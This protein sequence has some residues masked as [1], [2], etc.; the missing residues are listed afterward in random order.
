[1]EKPNVA[2]IFDNINNIVKFDIDLNDVSSPSRTF[3]TK[4]GSLDSINLHFSNKVIDFKKSLYKQLLIKVDINL[5][6]LLIEESKLRHQKSQQIL[7]K[8]KDVSTTLLDEKLNNDDQEEEYKFALR[9]L[10]SQNKAIGEVKLILLDT[11]KF[12]EYTNEEDY[13]RMLSELENEN[14]IETNKRNVNKA[15]FNLSKTDSILFLYMLEKF[16]ILK[17]ESSSQRKSFIEQNFNY[18]EYRN[19]EMASDENENIVKKLTGINV[20]YS[21]IKSIDKSNVKRYNKRLDLLK[22]KIQFIMEYEFKS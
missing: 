3:S 13:K 7:S 17:F 5:L 4:F 16:N 20:E 6:S 1:M 15:I 2:Q 21:N 10:N 22:D 12:I 19:I 14:N 8:F 9:I 18:T 11:I